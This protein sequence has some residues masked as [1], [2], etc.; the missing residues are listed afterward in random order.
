MATEVP[1][2][3][4]RKEV[5]DAAD[6]ACPGSGPPNSAACT[7]VIHLRAMLT[8]ATT[9]MLVRPRSICE[10]ARPAIDPMRVVIAFLCAYNSL[11]HGRVHYSDRHSTGCEESSIVDY[12][13]SSKMILS[14][15]C[16]KTANPMSIVT[17]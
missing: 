8:H 15:L 2:Q 10:E 17:I 13:Y 12:S 6:V 4:A 5:V 3:S 1:V 9:A 7:L 16:G 14:K 11:D